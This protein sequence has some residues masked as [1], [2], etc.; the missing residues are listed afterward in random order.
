MTARSYM[1]EY[2]EKN[3]LS[4][5]DM[6]KRCRTSTNLLDLLESSDQDVTRPKIA[7]RV[8]K[9]YKLTKKQA[10]GLIPENYRKSSPFYNPNLYKMEDPRYEPLCRRQNNPGNETSKL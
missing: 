8:S 2:R 3:G 9:A 6:A 1:I 5:K 7:K 10:E 4:L